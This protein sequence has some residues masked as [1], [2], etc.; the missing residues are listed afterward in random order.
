A[1]LRLRSPCH[2]GSSRVSIGRQGDEL[3]RGGAGSG[4]A[5]ARG[6]GERGRAGVGLGADAVRA[7]DRSVGPV[8]VLALHAAVRTDTGLADDAGDDA[9]AGDAIERHAALRDAGA[10]IPGLRGRG[11]DQGALV[12]HRDAHLAE[13]GRTLGAEPAQ[14]DAGRAGAP[15]AVEVGLTDGARPAG[16]A[17]PDPGLARP[18]AKLTFGADP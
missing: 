12:A 7:G 10:G 14:A 1:A 4:P 17:L 11:T 5:S 2:V 9:S 16:G 18:V 3:K 8:T 15:G 13:R 6:A